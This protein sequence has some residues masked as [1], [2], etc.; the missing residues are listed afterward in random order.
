LHK[1]Q[2]GGSGQYARVVGY[3]EPLDAD[4]ESNVVFEN[5]IIGNAIPPEYIAACEKGVNDAIQKGW[6]VGHP[7]NRIRVVINDGQAHAVD[8]S[9]L[10]FRTAMVQAIRQAFNKASPC[11]LEPVMSVEVEIPNEFQGNTIA[12]LNRRRGMIQ[13]SESDEISTVV[14]C[15]VPLQNMFGFSTDLRS[16]TQGKGEFTMEYKMHDVVARDVQEKL[17]DEYVKAQA[18][19][20]K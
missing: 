7:V 5:G 17:I 12:E 18:A 15:D 8:S 2:S 9:E 6:L 14:R 1:K 13:S 19:K 20:N 16:S 10:A 11:I 4:D 3:I